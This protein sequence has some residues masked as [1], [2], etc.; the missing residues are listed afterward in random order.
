MT[1]Q[2]DP[3]KANQNFR[4]H[5]VRFADGVA[6]LHDPLAVTISDPTSEDEERF[7]TIGADDRERVLVIVYTWRG[8]VVR[9]ISVRRSTARERRAYEERS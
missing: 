7:V 6:A 1:F 9:L 3:R 2:W 5:G 4:K 8:E